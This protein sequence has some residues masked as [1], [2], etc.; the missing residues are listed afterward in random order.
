M[1]Q[2]RTHPISR[3]EGLAHSVLTIQFNFWILVI[4]MVLFYIF[5]FLDWNHKLSC[6]LLAIF[7]L[8]ALLFALTAVWEF[9]TFV[10]NG[11]EV[12]ESMR[13]MFSRPSGYS[14]ASKSMGREPGWSTGEYE[15][16]RKPAPAPAPAPAQAPRGG[17]P[18]EEYGNYG[19]HYRDNS[20]GN[21]ER[22]DEGYGASDSDY[23]RGGK[24]FSDSGDGRY[25]EQGLGGSGGKERTKSSKS[26]RDR[27]KSER[28]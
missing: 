24:G 9:F 5:L 12:E 6:V 11:E 20:Y 21:Y 27:R 15:R 19:G 26:K 18:D 10:A 16:Q 17:Y 28:Y 4:I 3:R 23:S 25:V 1:G 2:G 13:L 7:G 22:G 8:F 14:Q